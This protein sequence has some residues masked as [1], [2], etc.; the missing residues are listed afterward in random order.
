MGMLDHFVVILRSDQG[1]V[2]LHISAR[3]AIEAGYDACRS[4]NASYRSIVS[5][6][7]KGK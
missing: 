3:D 2:E 4:Q 7:K 5:I 6:K 1:I